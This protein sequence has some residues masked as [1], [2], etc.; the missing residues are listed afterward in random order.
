MTELRRHPS[1]KT[2]GRKTTSGTALWNNGQSWLYPFFS[3]FLPFIPFHSL[4][5]FCVCDEV[6]HS[7]FMPRCRGNL[8]HSSGMSVSLLASFNGVPT[9]TGKTTI[10]TLPPTAQ[11]ANE[12]SPEGGKMNRSQRCRK[13]QPAL[14]GQ[15]ITICLYRINYST[16]IYFIIK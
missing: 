14:C 9:S 5:R 10:F 2:K 3:S 13:N 6:A 15:Y 1:R 16:L 12:W 7:F 8:H 4:S 11:S